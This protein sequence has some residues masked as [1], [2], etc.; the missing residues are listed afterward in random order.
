M[1]PVDGQAYGGDFA[2][3][4]TGTYAVRI[5]AIAGDLEG[6]LQTIAESDV[7]TFTVAALPIVV[8]LLGA[9][10]SSRKFTRFAQTEWSLRLPGDVAGGNLGIAI[11][12]DDKTL[13]PD[14]SQLLADNTLI[15]RW[16]PTYTGSHTL[17]ISQN[18]TSARWTADFEVEDLQI[19]PSRVAG[20]RHSDAVFAFH[21][22]LLFDGCAL[23]SNCARAGLSSGLQL[24]GVHGRS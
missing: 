9:E 6:S 16:T 23:Q 14:K 2:P 20:R 10:I 11:F 8:E 1:S 3:D 15:I 18:V 19:C 21:H 13:A 17:T 24:S 12:T 4:M 5:T 7:S 22:Q